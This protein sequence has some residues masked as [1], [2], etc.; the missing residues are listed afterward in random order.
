MLVSLWC[1]RR[2]IER[3]GLWPRNFNFARTIFPS[4]RT[5]T[6]HVKTLQKTMPEKALAGSFLTQC[7][8]SREIELPARRARGY[9]GGI[10][11]PRNFLNQI[12]F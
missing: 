10:V 4:E 8:A 7:G 5:C 1:G 6:R 12:F 11:R 3:Y 2:G 9:P